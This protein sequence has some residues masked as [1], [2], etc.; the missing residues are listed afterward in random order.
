MITVQEAG[1]RLKVE[2]DKGYHAE[3]IGNWAHLFWT[4]NCQK[5]S[6]DSISIFCRLASL[7]ETSEIQFTE[8][9]LYDIADRMIVGDC[10]PFDRPLKPSKI[11]SNM[12]SCMM[13]SVQ[14]VG[15]RL[16]AELDKGYHIERLANW[17]HLFSNTN[18]LE[19]SSDLQS[20]LNR[21]ASMPGAPEMEYSESELWQVATSMIEGNDH[22]FESLNQ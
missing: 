21:I 1:F 7:A 22:P 13:I 15:F 9:E 16:K 2:L 20:I 14:E 6:A 11:W 5:L 12:R 17:A 3:R 18:C 8:E 19:L 4:N 10:H